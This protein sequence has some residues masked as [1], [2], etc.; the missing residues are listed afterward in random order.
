MSKLDPEFYDCPNDC[1]HGKDCDQAHLYKF[2][3]EASESALKEAL[4]EA[5]SDY[6][7]EALYGDMLFIATLNRQ[8][9][10]RAVPRNA[11]QLTAE[12]L[13]ILRIEQNKVERVED[14][15]WRKELESKRK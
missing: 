12:C 7:F 5:S 14:W 6:S 2:F 11:S 3:R 8:L 10:K 13:S 15:R 4:K 1:T 9:G